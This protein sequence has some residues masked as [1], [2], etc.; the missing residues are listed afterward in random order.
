MFREIKQ[1]ITDYSG[2]FSEKTSIEHEVIEGMRQ[3]E[4]LKDR[5][6]SPEQLANLK[7]SSSLEQ[8]LAR[9][10]MDYHFQM[11]SEFN[12]TKAIISL[13]WSPK[14]EHWQK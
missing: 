1:S 10:W 14:T 2:P 12:P 11:R 13:D 9:A 8:L 6:L 3:R 4:K 5:D 7:S